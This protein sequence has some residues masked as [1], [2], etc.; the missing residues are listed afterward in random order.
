LAIFIRPFLPDK[1]YILKVYVSI[2]RVSQGFCQDNFL[3][4]LVLEFSLKIS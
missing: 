3:E 1:D 2:L 4:I